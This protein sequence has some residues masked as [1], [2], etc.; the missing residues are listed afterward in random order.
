MFL[1]K[2]SCSFDDFEIIM[3][4]GHGTQKCIRLRLLKIRGVEE[5][6]GGGTKILNFSRQ[7]KNK[8]VCLSLTPKRM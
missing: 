8:T 1:Q 6:L 5:F 4:Q 7:V 3:K 2:K